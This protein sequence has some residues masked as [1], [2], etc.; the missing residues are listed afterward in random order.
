M[1]ALLI[2]YISLVAAAIT[3]AR[4][5]RVPDKILLFGAGMTLGYLLGEARGV[6]L[7]TN[8]LA[9]LAIGGGLWLVNWL[10]FKWKKADAFGMGDVKWTMLAALGFGP[11]AALVAWPL[12][13]VFALL[14]M[15]AWRLAK[16]PRTQV[17]FA[18]F[19]CIGFTLAVGAA[20][21]TLVK[22]AL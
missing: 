21:Y 22:A 14:W 17:H 16:K 2:V 6:V 5:G 4:T 11:A 10:W 19:L 15:G 12:G 20:L 13:A 7:W 18:P 3:D 1:I 8:G 9:A